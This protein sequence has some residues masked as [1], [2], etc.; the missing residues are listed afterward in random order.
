[1]ASPQYHSYQREDF[2]F[3]LLCGALFEVQWSLMNSGGSVALG[4]APSGLGFNDTRH[5]AYGST[6]TSLSL[7]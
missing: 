4:A 3:T 1:M 5:T 2:V 6:T 7:S